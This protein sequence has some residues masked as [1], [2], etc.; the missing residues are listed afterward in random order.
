[1]IKII[2]FTFSWL[3]NTK[4]FHEPDLIV[5]ISYANNATS[6]QRIPSVDRNS[7]KMFSPRLKT[8]L[9]SRVTYVNSQGFWPVFSW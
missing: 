6:L 8:F 2:S 3:R 9:F 5:K 7:N 4:Y 1:M